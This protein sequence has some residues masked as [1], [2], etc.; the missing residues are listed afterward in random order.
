MATI[1]TNMV[2]LPVNGDGARGYLAQPHDDVKHPGLVL[3]QEYW[4]VETHIID[5]AQKMA[6]QGF[7]TLVPDLY[8]GRVATEPDDA[9]REVMLLRSSIES[10]MQEI[11][12]ALTYLMELPEVDPKK[13]GVIGFCF[14]G[15]LT[16][17]A[18][19]R[20]PE[21]G[22]AVPFYGGGYDPTPEDIAGVTAPILA[23]YGEKDGGIPPEQIQKITSTYKASGKDYEA[24]IYP[25]GHAFL[26]PNHGA[27]HGE[28]A[29]KAW[30]EA[31]AFLK[32]HLS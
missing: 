25:A 10:A 13:M 7:V 27:Y 23:F 31:I 4:G 19:E 28:S 1:R 29:V 15:N 17:R 32:Q 11:H 9:R 12:G 20:F 22:V 14:G 30:A 6:A 24:R 26:N 2:P 5:L 16:Y 18:A 8:H 21:V 3:I